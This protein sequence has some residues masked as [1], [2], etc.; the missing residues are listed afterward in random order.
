MHELEADHE[1]ADEWHQLVDQL[2]RKWLSATGLASH[3]SE[4]LNQ[5]LANLSQLYSR[6][7][8]LEDNSL[9]PVAAAVLA[10]TEKAEIAT[11][12]AHRRGLDPQRLAEKLVDLN[13]TIQWP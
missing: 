7:I 1:Q 3:D 6:H 10:G 9:F 12:M 13:S 5:A 2:G 8:A 4:P 11:E